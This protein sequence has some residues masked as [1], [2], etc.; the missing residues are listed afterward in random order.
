MTDLRNLLIIDDD[1]DIRELLSVI[2]GRFNIPFTLAAH[3]EEAHEAVQK[4]RNNFTNVLIDYTLPGG[5]NGLQLA[6]KIRESLP[7]A[8]I[9]ITSGYSQSMA[10]G[11]LSAKGYR[12]LEKPFTPQ[13]FLDILKTSDCPA[14]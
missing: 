12:F 2:L 7:S 14:G 11:D 8:D 5:T 1:P 6:D 9:T 4:G 3:P 10:T 13:E